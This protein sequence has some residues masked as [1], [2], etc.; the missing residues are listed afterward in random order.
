LCKSE[1]RKEKENAILSKTEEKFLQEINSLSEKLKSPKTKFKKAEAVQRSIGR[2]Q[3]KYSRAARYYDITYESGNITISK[4]A[5]YD[6]NVSLHGCYFLRSSFSDI[7]EDE[8]WRLYINL[9][10]VEEAFRSMKKE[11]GLRPFRHHTDDRCDSHAWI[12]VLAYHLQR[13]IEYSLEIAGCPTSWRN[14]KLL[15]QTHCY[16]TLSIPSADGVVRRMRK[17]GKPDEKQRAIYQKLN[18]EYRKLPIIRFE[19]LKKM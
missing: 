15:L 10:R 5:S 3:Q 7:S 11:L 18:V 14:L 8:V 13:W 2:I 1:S 19:K 9:T 6:E 4:K 17:A 12:T 16:S